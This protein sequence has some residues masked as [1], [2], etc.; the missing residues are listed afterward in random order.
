MF[1]EL[2]RQQKTVTSILLLIL[3]LY[4]MLQQINLLNYITV[5]F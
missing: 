3:Q 2:Y 5:Q 1:H 4:I